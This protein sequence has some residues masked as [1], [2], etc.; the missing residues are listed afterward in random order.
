MAANK[1]DA[2]KDYLELARNFVFGN[3]LVV[4]AGS[5]V[6]DK[7][8]IGDFAARCIVWVLVCASFAYVAAAIYYV[9]YRHK[10]EA[11]TRKQ[12]VLGGARAA[13]LFVL[14]EASLIMV[15]RHID[16]E[17]HLQRSAHEE[18]VTCPLR[19]SR[20]RELS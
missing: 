1:L 12:L 3:G 4:I 15:G 6:R 13:F 10:P 5:V 17:N 18:N 19:S 7:A 20:W 14:M 11:P 2:L 16:R 8:S 9:E